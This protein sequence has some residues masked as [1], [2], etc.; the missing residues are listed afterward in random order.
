MEIHIFIQDSQV[1]TRDAWQQAIEEAGF[2]AVLDPTLD[3]RKDAGFSPTV[4]NGQQSGFELNLDAAG[5]YLESY[6]HI[7]EQVGGRD[8]CVSFRW[9]GDIVEAAAAISCAAALTRLTDGIYFDPETDRVFSADV[10][11]DGIKEDLSGLS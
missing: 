3:L 7:A 4:Y 2:P 1:P 6:P 8:S 10:V 5:S 11:L 9:G